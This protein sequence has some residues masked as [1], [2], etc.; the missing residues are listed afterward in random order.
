MQ[1]RCQL[2]VLSSNKEIRPNNGFFDLPAL[3]KPMVQLGAAGKTAAA[4]TFAR[5]I[6]HLWRAAL[7]PAIPV[8]LL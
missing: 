7:D 2:V 5:K 6:S 8:F 3:R 4:L 1:D